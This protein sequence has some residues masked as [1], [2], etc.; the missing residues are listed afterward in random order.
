MLFVSIGEESYYRGLIYENL[1]RDLGTAPARIIDMVIFPA[2]QLWS[3]VQA[4]LGTGTILFDF[5]WRSAM[6]FVFD[7]AYDEGGCPAGRRL[8]F[9]S[10]PILAWPDGFSPAADGFRSDPCRKALPKTQ[11]VLHFHPWPI[12]KKLPSAISPTATTAPGRR[13]NA[14]S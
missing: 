13:T 3:D 14:G 10:E 6:T 8:A 5:A 12:R 2:I 9:S 4:N 11:S 7:S 1:K